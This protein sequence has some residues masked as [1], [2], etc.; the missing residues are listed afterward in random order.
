MNKLFTYIAASFDTHNQG[1][2]ARKL[3]A[4]V[5]MVLICY[6]HRFVS[7][8]NVI[9]V[10]IADSGLLCVLLGI[11]TYEKIKLNQPP[12]NTPTE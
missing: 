1:A 8:T 2:S 12:T 7:E 6:A 4:F 5:T 9:E 11:T 10:I 3:S